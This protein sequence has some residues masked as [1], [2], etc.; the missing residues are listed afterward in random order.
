[1][2]QC[3]LLK[4]ISF[5]TFVTSILF[6]IDTTKSALSGTEIQPK[7]H[8]R[9]DSECMD[10]T[11]CTSAGSSCQV[12]GPNRVTITGVQSYGSCG[13]HTNECAEYNSG[14]SLQCS[15]NYYFA[16]TDT[17]CSAGWVL[18]AFTYINSTGRCAGL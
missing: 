9:T 11:P 12:Q 7:T 13:I 14:Q 3:L 2:K 10:P 18:Q 8:I 1:M 5:A 17:D 4:T 6:I 16:L 15:L